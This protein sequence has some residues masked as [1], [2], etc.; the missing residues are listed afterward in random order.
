VASPPAVLPPLAPPTIVMSSLLHSTSGEAVAPQ[1]RPRRCNA[2]YDPPAQNGNDF[3]TVPSLA[4][5]ADGVVR[6][7]AE[8]LP[9]VLTASQRG[10][11][12][13]AAARAARASISRKP[14]SKRA[15][16]TP[17]HLREFTSGDDSSD[18]DSDLEL[19]RLPLEEQER[20]LQQRMATGGNDKDARR[21]KR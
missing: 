6:G 11:L 18:V 12:E 8:P 1:T 16:Q 7:C 3:H 2:A 13:L 4:Q 14:T 17:T 21:L 19:Q 15:R 10:E 20:L 5:A 9:A